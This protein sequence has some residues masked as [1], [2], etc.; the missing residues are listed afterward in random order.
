[1]LRALGRGGLLPALLLLGSPAVGRAGEPMIKVTPEAKTE[2]PLGLEVAYPAKHPVGKTLKVD[3][4][5]W[6]S[7]DAD[8]LSV[9]IRPPAEVAW[10]KGKREGVWRGVKAHGKRTLTFSIAPE[11]AGAHLV[12]VDVARAAGGKVAH[13]TGAFLVE[14]GGAV[15]PPA[16]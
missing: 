5:V 3:V 10:K 9:V 1:M 15:T 4:T 12:A 2:G 8:E 6:S 13:R 7:D 14:G 11:K 16:K